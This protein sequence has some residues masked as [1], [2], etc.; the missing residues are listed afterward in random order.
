MN[1]KKIFTG[2]IVVL[3]VIA[4]VCLLV[5]FLNKK[6]STSVD[7]TKTEVNDEKSDVENNDMKDLDN[8]ET[9]DE[10]TNTDENISVKEETTSQQFVS[11]P[12][13]KPTGT[14]QTTIKQE[15]KVTPTPV[16]QKQEN[17]EIKQPTTTP[18][19]STEEKTE[20]N[21]P[22]SQPEETF[23][24]NYEMIEK[25]KQTI[26][27]NET[28]DMKTYGYEIVVDSSIKG[29]TNP[30]TFTELR[31]KNMIKYSFGTIRIYAENYYVGGELV[32][33]NCYI[34]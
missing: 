7:N 1:K 8:K 5:V 22:T 23:A 9:E 6:E 27:A 29:K 14:G 25:I 15:N 24:P 18:T 11:T 32:M 13:P 12:T 31:V 26:K 16:T 3:V 19:Q 33:V 2:I 17:A 4:I 34:L 20:N 10:N 21:T 30:F 28:E